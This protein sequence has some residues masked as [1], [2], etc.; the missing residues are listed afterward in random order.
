M[1]L[2]NKAS[3]INCQKKLVVITS[4]NHSGKLI[5]VRKLIFGFVFKAYVVMLN[6]SRGIYVKIKTKNSSFRPNV[7]F[8]EYFLKNYLTRWSER[9]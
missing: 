1:H 4:L 6:K 7:T 2:S 5:R 8:E 9:S 3:E